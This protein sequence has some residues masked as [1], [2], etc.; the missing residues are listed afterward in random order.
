MCWGGCAAQFS[1]NDFSGA[2]LSS[3]TMVMVV[4]H[5]PAVPEVWLV[6]LTL[7]SYLVVLVSCMQQVHVSRQNEGSH[8]LTICDCV[9]FDARLISVYLGTPFI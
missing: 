1:N 6:T 3:P 2:V 9:L 5:V 8:E 4:V 7:Y